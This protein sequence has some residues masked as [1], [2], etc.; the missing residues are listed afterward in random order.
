M[1]Y[2]M[3]DEHI[4]AK[5]EEH[6]AIAIHLISTLDQA[7]IYKKA[8]TKMTL[9][10]SDYYTSYNTELAKISKEIVK[11]EALRQHILSLHAHYFKTQEQRS[12]LLALITMHKTELFTDLEECI[13]EEENC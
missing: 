4:H 5:D 6:A 1:K 2:L 13:D 11:V 9:D 12:A 3:T 7:S 10:I 8:L